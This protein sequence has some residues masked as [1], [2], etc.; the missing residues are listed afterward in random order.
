MSVRLPVCLSCA[1]IVTK[2]PQPYCNT[3]F[4]Q[5]FERA[6]IERR[7]FEEVAQQ[8]EKQQEQDELRYEI[9]T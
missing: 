9:S 3:R 6:N 8:K 7:L 2:Q 4:I 1:G 5:K